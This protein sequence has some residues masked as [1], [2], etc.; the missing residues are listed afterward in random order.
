MLLTD[1]GVAK[2]PTGG[3]AGARTAVAGNSADRRTCRVPVTILT[4]CTI[5]KTD[6]LE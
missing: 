4:V 6:K 2:S 1:I 5:E 3:A